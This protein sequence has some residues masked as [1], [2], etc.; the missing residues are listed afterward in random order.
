MADAMSKQHGHKIINIMPTNLYG[1]GDN[2]S[3][4]D[5]HVIPGLIHR[6][7]LATVNNDSECAIWGSGKPLREF[8]FVDDLSKCIEFIIENEINEKIINVGSGEEISILNLAELIKT[9]L[10]FGGKLKFDRNKPDGNP[11][12]LLD[13]SFINDLA[14]LQQLLFT[15]V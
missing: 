14:G 15:K 4:N 5:S 11:R 13:S 9:K 8:L 3:L 12:K 10:H 2:F 1:P 7:H 6:M